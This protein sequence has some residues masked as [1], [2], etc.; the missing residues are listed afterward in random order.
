MIRVCFP[1]PY[2]RVN[3]LVLRSPECPV[4]AVKS[5]EPLPSWESS[6]RRRGPGSYTELLLYRDTLLC[7][8]LPMSSAVLDFTKLKRR[9]CYR[10]GLSIYWIYFMY[11]QSN[12]YPILLYTALTSEAL[13]F[14]LGV[15][16]AARSGEMGTGNCQL[17]YR[18]GLNC[19]VGKIAEWH[20]VNYL[21]W[22][23]SCVGLLGGGVCRKRIFTYF[24]E[25]S[26]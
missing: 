23:C 1:K 15:H 12:G 22:S 17:V 21:I 19:C 4:R 11:S 6:L 5:P 2:P 8:G 25:L 9:I 3:P 20:F 13:I 26:Y 16:V 14:G 24:P 18:E 10:N 7:Q